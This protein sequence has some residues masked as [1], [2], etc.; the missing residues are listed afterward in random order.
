[1]RQLIKGDICRIL[2]KK[3]I[4]I[5]AVILYIILF[6]VKNKDDPEEQMASFKT[7][8]SAIGLLLCIIPVYLTVYGDEIRTGS[9]QSVI[10]RGLSRT[11]VIISKLLD[12]AILFALMFIVF[13]LLFYVKNLIFQVA[14]SPRQNLMAFIF[15]LINC[16]K[17][18]GY[19]ALASLFLFTSWNVAIGLTSC[20]MM[21]F[22]NVALALVQESMRIPVHDYWIDGLLSS[23]FNDISVGHFPW[24][25]I[26]MILVYIIGVLF[27]TVKIFDRKELDL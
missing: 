2:K 15:V 1:M 9:M 16:V 26:I 11:K 3:E 21:V 25:L 19:F 10:G 7:M 20:I 17:A 4:Y 5:F 23:A 12:C 8:V 14:L 22:I 24:K 18:I 6:A 13:L 27:L